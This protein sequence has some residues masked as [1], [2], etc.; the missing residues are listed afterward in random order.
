MTM[1][2][3]EYTLPNGKKAVFEYDVCGI[4]KITLEC[5]DELMGMI[6]DRPQGYWTKTDVAT[7]R[8]SECGK[9]QI[10]DDVNE[11]NFCCC[12]G[13]RNKVRRLKGADD[14]V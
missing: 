6:T 4:G 7:Y 8:C 3:K 1:N 10:A 9:I 5:M 14:E 11:L 12:C 2:S 13:S